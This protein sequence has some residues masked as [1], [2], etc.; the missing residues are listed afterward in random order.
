M[1]NSTKNN[2]MDF[3][4]DLKDNIMG[5]QIYSFVALIIM[6]WKI[7]FGN[8]SA[9]DINTGTILGILSIIGGFVVIKYRKLNKTPIAKVDWQNIEINEITLLMFS[10]K[11]VI[12]FSEVKSIR[13]NPNKIIIN[14]VKNKGAIKVQFIHKGDFKRLEKTLKQIAEK[15]KIETKNL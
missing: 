7:Y 14:G 6:A 12:N 5:M 8:G 3:L 10:R 11:K 2:T 9:W 4:F 15:Y 1:K 13:F